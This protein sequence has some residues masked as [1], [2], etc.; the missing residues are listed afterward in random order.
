MRGSLFNGVIKCSRQSSIDKKSVLTHL[1]KQVNCSREII[2]NT[3]WRCS[4]SLSSTYV[5]S[6]LTEFRWCNASYIQL[7]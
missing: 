1:T 6:V 4:F 5:S 7:N 2:I 3:V